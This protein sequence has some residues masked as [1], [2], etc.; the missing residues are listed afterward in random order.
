MSSRTMLTSPPLDRRWIFDSLLDSKKL[1]L[2]PVR[3][4]NPQYVTLPASRSEP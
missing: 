2:W 1:I 4:V 3:D